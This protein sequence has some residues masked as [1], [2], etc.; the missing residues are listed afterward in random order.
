[1]VLLD[2]YYVLDSLGSGFFLM[3]FSCLKFK[4]ASLASKVCFHPL[5]TGK[6]FRMNFLSFGSTFFT[7]MRIWIPNTDLSSNR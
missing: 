4:N 7:R 6:L 3:P 1:M 5:G 2:V